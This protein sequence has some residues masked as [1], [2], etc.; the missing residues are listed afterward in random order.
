VSA[1]R[2]ALLFGW[3]MVLASI[4]VFST[5]LPPLFDYPNH[6]AR[7]HLLAEGGNQFYSVAWAPLPNLAEDLI[8]P[9]LASVVTLAVAGKLF[10]VLIFLLLAGGTI[11]LGREATGA[12]RCWPFLGF[13]LLYT[14]TF[15]WGFENY[16]F[17]TGLAFCGLALWLRLERAPPPL[18]VLASMATAFAC[19]LSHVEA[20][21]VYA[22]ALGGLEAVPG[23]AEL[24]A[25]LKQALW[26]RFVLAAPQFI[27]PTILF[28]AT[29]TPLAG[30]GG[31][32]YARFW[33]KADILFSVFDN[34]DR[35]FDAACF[36]G[37]VLLFLALAWR[38]RLGLT[39]RLAAAAA[40]VFGAY[41]V[42]PSQLFSGSGADHRLPAAIFLLVIAGSAPVFPSRAVAVWTGLAVTAVLLARLGVIEWVWWRSD[43]IYAADIAALDALPAGA[44]LAV[45]FPPGSEN[46]APIP[47]IHLATLAIARR[48]AFVPTLFAY[49]AQQ[50]I[51]LNPP[52]AALAAAVQPDDL[53]S[54]FVDHDTDRRARLL[55]LLA[56]FDFVLFTARDVIRVP[57]DPCLTPVSMTQTFQ[58]YRFAYAACGA[59]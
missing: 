43:A 57:P 25:G 19:Y 41:L 4:P 21:A 30:G 11:W 10:L 40:A 59:D 15:L 46:M 14:R 35:P 44:K 8:V 54:L 26:R 45:A 49:P 13:G 3:L 36:A 23:F 42:L 39:P 34:Y 24:Q 47:E 37:F 33:R 38:N 17:G 5:V 55:P 32:S 9:A 51:A 1:H 50:P 53:W 28:L 56:Q 18:R 31:W 2:A 22:L 52:F 29:W 48:E 58:L 16:L 12:W 20:F 6:L 27:L 7:M